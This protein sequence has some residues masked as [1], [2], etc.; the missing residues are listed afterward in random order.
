MSI[1]KLA[2]AA[3]L[4]SSMTLGAQET[5]SAPTDS[6]HVGDRVR[7]RIGTSGSGNSIIGNVK[8]IVPDT[9]ELTLPGGRGTVTIPRLA[10]DEVAQSRGM[11][12]FRPGAM[13]ALPLVGL[14]LISIPILA[15]PHQSAESRAMGIGL[16]LTQVPLFARLFQSQTR[17]R[18]EPVSAWLN[19]P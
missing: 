16:A 17:E 11:E 7:L 5:L 19:Q 10:I 18:W 12:S 6:L 9:L 8:R 13:R 14:S 4:L 2:G 3:L 1:L 15:R